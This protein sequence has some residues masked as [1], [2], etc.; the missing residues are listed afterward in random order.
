MNNSDTIKPNRPEP[1]VSDIEVLAYKRNS[2]S[3]DAIDVLLDDGFVLIFDFYS[4]GLALLKELKSFVKKQYPGNSFQ[5]QR[6]FRSAY[7]KLSNKII[8]SIA[9]NKLEVRKAPDIGWLKILYP[10]FSE[11]ALSFPNVQGLNSSWQWYLKGIKI[12]VLKQKIFPYYGTYFPTRFEHLELFDNWLYSYNGKKKSAIDI[13][14]GSGIIS[15]QL[16]KHKFAQVTASD[17][18]PNSII[19]VEN[20]ISRNKQYRNIDLFFG[21]LFTD[22]NFCSELIVFNP[23]WIPTNSDIKNLDQAIYYDENLFPDFFSEAKKHLLQNGK[24]AILFSNLAQITNQSGTNPIEIE[25]ATGNR[26]KLDSLLKKEVKQASNKTKRIL[27]WRAN[28]EVELWIL[29]H[30]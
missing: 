16:I 19:G 17:I 23:P 8:L 10:D 14:V 28:E 3:Q 24:I 12:T 30:K 1:I 9:D 20:Y 25:I 2:N 22:I 4:T 26:F 29:T 5:Q 11:F 15:F 13:G 7:H 27:N 6:D 18:N 21:D